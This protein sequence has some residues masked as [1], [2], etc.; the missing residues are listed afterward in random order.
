M[1]FFAA[2][3]QFDFDDCVLATFLNNWPC[4]LQSEVKISKADLKRKSCNGVFVAIVDYP[5]P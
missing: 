2:K 4:Y 1:V 3:D 5:F